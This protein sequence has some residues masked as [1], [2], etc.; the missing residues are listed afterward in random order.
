MNKSRARQGLEEG[1]DQKAIPEDMMHLKMR[2]SP[3]LP[4]QLTK[5]ETL[6]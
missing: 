2:K 3:D 1:E 5:R 6:R 4:M